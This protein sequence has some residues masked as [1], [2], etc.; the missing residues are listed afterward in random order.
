MHTNPQILSLNL[1]VRPD[2][3]GTF[4]LYKGEA[5]RHLLN[6]SSA[7]DY[8]E[9]METLCTALLKRG[10]PPENHI[11]YDTDKRT[12][13]LDK[14]ARRDDQVNTRKFD[15]RFKVLVF[16]TQYGSHIKALSIKKETNKL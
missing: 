13:I 7:N 12:T 4:F 8:D 14:L 11:P 1:L 15:C 2:R 16:T 6:C 9:R 3:G 5:A 10:H